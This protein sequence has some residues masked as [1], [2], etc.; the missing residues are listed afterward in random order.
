[1]YL[2]EDCSNG[3]SLMHMSDL[4]SISKNVE[5]KVLSFLY[6]TAGTECVAFDLLEFQ[7]VGSKGFLAFV[8]LSW[9]EYYLTQVADA[10][11]FFVLQ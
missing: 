3:F 5:Y 4:L 1:M 2:A 8:G 7:I 10:L 6:R 9:S 11:V